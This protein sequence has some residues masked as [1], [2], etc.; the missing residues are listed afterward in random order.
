LANFFKVGQ[1]TES[2]P[3]TGRQTELVP[4]TPN[5][6]SVRRFLFSIMRQEKVHPDHNHYFSYRTLKQLLEKF[7]LNC[8]E[9]YYYQ[10]VEGQGLSRAL[11]SAVAF[12]TR[13]LPC[14]QMV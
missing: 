13:L 6:T 5:A 1:D 7:G 11:D 14:G 8:R 3:I 10:E 2:T 9:I 12:T 4:T